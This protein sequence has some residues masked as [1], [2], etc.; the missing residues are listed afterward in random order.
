VRKI[1]NDLGLGER[2]A[3]ALESGSE[4]TLR[5]RNAS[6]QENGWGPRRMGRFGSDYS[7]C[8]S[9]SSRTARGRKSKPINPLQN[10]KVN[11][12]PGY[13]QGW[14]PGARSAG[15][16]LALLVRSANYIAAGLTDAREP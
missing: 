13:R 11:G 14:S 12:P 15:W 9:V 1:V 8:N 4:R 3:I 10:M 5:H 2:I 16:Q 6:N 7:A